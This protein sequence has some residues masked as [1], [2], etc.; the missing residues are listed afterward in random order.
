MDRDEAII[1]LIEGPAPAEDSSLPAGDEPPRTHR[2]GSAMSLGE[3]LERRRSQRAFTGEPLLPTE[4]AALAWAAQGETTADGKR[5]V[6]SA[7]NMHSLE[8]HV[9]TPEGQYRYLPAED[10]LDLVGRGD[11]RA[12]LAHACVDQDFLAA[13]GALFVI[14]NARRASH[15]RYGGRADRY[16]T[17]EA[18]HMAQNLLLEATALGLAAI[19]IGAFYDAEVR[20]EA[21]FAKGVD[22]LYI[23]AVGRAGAAR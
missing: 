16:A 1:E 6:P 7:G 9:I 11:R 13:A 23:V 4:L 19:P 17:L 18:G 21:G 8:L 5:T 20:V 22:P 15:D 12:R 2:A 3:A 10:E 14:A